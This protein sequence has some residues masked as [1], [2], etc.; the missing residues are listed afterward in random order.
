MAA[1]GVCGSDL[2]RIGVLKDANEALFSV[3][4]VYL[5]RGISTEGNSSVPFQSIEG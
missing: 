4:Q 3:L 2:A 1:V 5:F